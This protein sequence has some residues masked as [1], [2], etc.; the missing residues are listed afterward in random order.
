[1][2]GWNKNDKDSQEEKI[3]DIAQQNH[4]Q[5]STIDQFAVAQTPFHTHNGSDS[6][7]IPYTNI[8]GKTIVIAYT[9]FG[10]QAATAG[11]FS[12]FFTAPVAMT[13]SKATEVHATAG[14]DGSAV[15]LQIEKL[16]GTTAPGSGTSLLS[17]PFNLKGTAN[18]VTTGVLTTVSPFLR[19][20]SGDRAALKLTGTPTS[21]NNVTVI[22]VFTII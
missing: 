16:T 3:R 4:D 21:V 10:T 18:T 2:Q 5:N 17:T 1:M 6:P 12:A 9:I 15:S 22:C 13:L 11:N 20:A 8:Q 7:F 14:S 19:F